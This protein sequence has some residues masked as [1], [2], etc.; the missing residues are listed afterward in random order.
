[1]SASNYSGVLIRYSFLSFI[2]QNALLTKSLF[3]FSF[4]FSLSLHNKLTLTGCIFAKTMDQ[5]FHF[6][7]LWCKFVEAHRPKLISYGIY[8]SMV[9]G[10]IYTTGR[11]HFFILI[12][13][14]KSLYSH[15]AQCSPG[16][17]LPLLG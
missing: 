7:L 2:L 8:K 15:S 16:L 5:I 4:P 9:R 3:S 13:I 6:L 17:H 14:L 12:F 10:R 1:M 11:L